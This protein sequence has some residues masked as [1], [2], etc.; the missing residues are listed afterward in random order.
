MTRRGVRMERAKCPTCAKT[1]G[2]QP[3]IGGDGS[4]NVFPRHIDRATGSF[5]VESRAIV[6][7]NAYVEGDD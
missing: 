1:M 5:C 7:D 2:V 4:V 3:P 6:R